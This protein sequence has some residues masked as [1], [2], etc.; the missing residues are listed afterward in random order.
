MHPLYRPVLD[1]MHRVAR[2][3]MMPRFRNLAAHEY[4]EKTPGDFVTVVDRE[5]EALLGEEPSR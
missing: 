1:L 4:G 3:I 2:D 5:S